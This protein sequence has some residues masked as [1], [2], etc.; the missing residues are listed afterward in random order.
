M[1]NR[2]LS[3]R[4]KDKLKLMVDVQSMNPV[5]LRRNIGYVIQQ[6]G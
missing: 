3:K 2:I 4:Q 6:L 5:E 1:I